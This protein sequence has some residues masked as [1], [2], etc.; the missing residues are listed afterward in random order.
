MIKACVLLVA[1]V[2]SRAHLFPDSSYLSWFRSWAAHPPETPDALQEFATRMDQI[3]FEARGLPTDFLDKCGRWHRDLG[4][5]NDHCCTTDSPC[6]AQE[7]DCDAD[8]DCEGTLQCGHRNCAW[9]GDDD[10][11]VAM[12]SIWGRFKHSLRGSNP[13]R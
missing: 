10:C 1:V 12:F 8:D 2:G 5:G 7:G 13:S 4:P 6:G 9:D 3:E 11:C